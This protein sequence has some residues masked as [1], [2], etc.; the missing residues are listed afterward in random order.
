M[1]TKTKVEFGYAPMPNSKLNKTQ[2]QVVASEFK[3]LEEKHR[4]LKPATI[5]E[6]ARPQGSRLH[7]F[8]T[9][10]DRA[11][12]EQYRLIEAQMLS[13]SVR[14]FQVGIPLAEQ[15]VVRA[16]VHVTA[17]SEE[18]E[19]EGPGYISVNRVLDDTRYREQMLQEARDD[20]RIFQRKYEDLLLVTGAMESVEKVKSKL[21]P[22]PRRRGG[23]R[24]K[25]T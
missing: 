21:A 18:T 10:D 12:A 6:A 7:P 2:V 23:A 14:I 22:K 11:A 15:P 25:A 3:R 17:H 4:V 24:H 1:S 9:W 19:F 8:F 20:I 13:R 5:V 16:W